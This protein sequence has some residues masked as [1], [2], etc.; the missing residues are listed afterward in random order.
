MLTKEKN[1]VI[2]CIE[3][4]QSSLAEISQKIWQ[5]AE[6]GL[7]E[8]RSSALLAEKLERH[9]FRVET[10]VAGMPTAFVATFGE[11]KPAIGII[12]EYD[13][14]PGLSND[15]VPFRSPIV[16]GAPGHG[17]GHN[18]FGTASAAA[19]I[20][21]KQ[22]MET[23]H[24]TGTLKVFGTPAEEVCIGKPYMAK[25][26]CFDG[27]DVFLDWHPDEVTTPLYA[28]C[29]AYS[30]V[31]FVFHGTS[32]HG[33][34]PWLG[35]SALEAAELMGVAVNY[36]RGRIDPGHPPMGASTINYT[37]LD[38][39]KYPNVVPDRSEAWYVYRIPTRGELEKIHERVL[40]CARGA[41]LATETTFD[42]NILTGTH[43]LIPNETLANLLHRNLEIVGPPQFD[44]EEE[45]FART[46]QEAYQKQP[47]G[48]STRILPPS[49]GSK[50]VT[51]SSEPSWFAPYAVLRVACRPSGI[52][53]HSW[54]ANASCGM[55][56]GQKGMLVAAKT[57]GL[58]GLEIVMSPELLEPMKKEFSERL[59][60]R[61]YSS[62]VPKGQ[63]PPLPEGAQV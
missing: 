56:I 24:L 9:G 40:N 41:A 42:V 31:R 35:R 48:L 26:G 60:G 34:R 32:A 7:E 43:E 47:V 1:A 12:A 37:F 51:D 54:G 49:G 63:N 62:V 39:G 22:A 3:D 5:Y 61:A 46:L 44:A 18:L 15:P 58:S 14:L 45:K 19:A 50:G 4:D 23:F 11:G 55:S 25:E 16:E 38:C 27:V 57:L 10:G 53:G 33:N 30:S 52:P 17:C 36:L 13:A 28:T 21:L 6:I 20:A 29:N 8:H 2:D 59:A